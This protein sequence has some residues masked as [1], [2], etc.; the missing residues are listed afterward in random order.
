M[1]KALVRFFQIVKDR[2]KPDKWVFG[3]RGTQGAGLVEPCSSDRCSD[4]LSAAHAA[5]WP[6]VYCFTG[7]KPEG[8]PG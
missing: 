1:S 3:A 4:A 8:W 7:A 2:E 5:A 6:S